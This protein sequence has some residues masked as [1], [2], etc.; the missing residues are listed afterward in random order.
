MR[1]DE[2]LPNTG[3]AGKSTVT[4]IGAGIAGLVAAY[5]LEQLG[6][7]VEVLEGSRRIGGR[8]Y[9][10]RF[11]F[12]AEAP[13][14]EL[15]AMRIPTKHRHT[16]EYISRL[17][18]A[19]ELR[20]FKSLLADEN[21]FLKTSTG[22]V[23][24]R[25]APQPLLEDLRQGL[26]HNGYREE[27]LLFGAGLSL[28]VNAIAPPAVREGLRQA[29]HAELLDLADRLD[30][31]PHL[32][33]NG[34]RQMDVHAVF[35][36]HPHLQ[37]ACKGDLGSFLDDIL[38]ETD[39][40][41]V[42]V[43]GGMSRIV[44]RLARRIQGRILRGRE[45]LSLDVRPDGV[46]MGIREGG[47]IVSRHSRYVVCTVP[48]PVLRR[49]RLTGLS[50]D[51]LDAIRQVQYVSATKVALHCREP[52]WEGAGITAGASCSGGRIRQTY[53]PCADGDPALGAVLLASYTIGDDA[54]LLGRL[55]SAARY[56]SI[57]AE[58]AEMHPELLRPGMVLNAASIAWGQH[59]WSGG[60]CSVRWGKDA[61]ACE[62]ERIRAA[63]PQH[64]LFFAGEHCSSTPAWIDGA[65]ESAVVAVRQLVLHDAEPGTAKASELA[66][67][68]E[69]S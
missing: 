45:V 19:G 65:I 18:L 12:E 41:L 57:I 62:E 2:A 38:T 5:E 61:A 56:A 36:A 20:P 7:Q 28:I 33:E 37:A 35:A 44:Q 48:F 17:G 26:S 30:L 49:M 24:L 6:Y 39:S 25:N 64:T 4:V 22:F 13:V 34:T 23:R 11:G 1:W 21:A 68:A 14:A 46:V 66:A 31:R 50:Q 16:M 69:V 60:G 40:E 54:D 42:R 67:S 27:T 3:P 43:R 51:K 63:R 9:T 53:Y 58:L 15:G 55:P 59:R 47:R 29:L 52:F 32:R 10:H 8:I